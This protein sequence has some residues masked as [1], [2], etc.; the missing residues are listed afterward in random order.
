[1]FKKAFAAMALA[2]MAMSAHA[3]TIVINEGFDTITGANGLAAKGWS[4]VNTSN[5]VPNGWFGGSTNIFD[6]QSGGAGSYVAAGYALDDGASRAFS[7]WLYSPVFDATG[8]A[9]V[10]FWLRGADD[11]DFYDTVNYGILLN[12]A[13]VQMT[14]LATV[15]TDGWTQY[16][17]T[18]D[19]STVGTGRFAIQYASNVAT[20]NYVGLDSV[21]VAVPEPA[22]LALI[23]FGALGL[24]IARRRRA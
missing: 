24:G 22:S 23:A 3:N 21:T 4:G 16:T 11:P 10:S 2:G 14:A 17:L 7:N 5:G 15:A 8:G 9:T 1:M 20:S 13:L 18:L 19:H 12:G 6:G